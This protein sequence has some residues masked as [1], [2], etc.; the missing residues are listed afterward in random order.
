MSFNEFFKRFL[1]VLIILLLWAGLWA[2]RST[3]LM[4]VAS[5]FIAVALSIPARWLQNHGWRRPWALVATIV[6]VLLLA[7][8]L[9]LWLVPQLLEE[10][11]ALLNTIPDALR[12][13][14]EV[15]RN[16]RNSNPFLQA[17]LSE[18]PQLSGTEVDPAS[19]RALLSQFLN[20]GLA[21]A[22]SLLGGVSEVVTV[23]INLGFVIFIAVFFIVDPYSYVKAILYLTPQR[24]H[25]RVIDILNKLYFTVRTWVSTLFLSISITMTLV[26][27]ILGV[28]LDMPNALVV[29]V[30]AGVATFIPNIG[31]F[32]PIIP[33]AIFT[34][35]DDPSQLLIRIAA[36]LLIQLT[37]SNVLTPSLVKA[38]LDI[39][40]GGL[41]IF[42]LLMTFAFGA[43]GLLLA[44]PILSVLIVLVRE[45]F[46]YDLL[47]LRHLSVELDTDK[48]G[49]LE[50]HEH[51]VES[52]ETET[53]V[54]PEVVPMLP[55][56]EADVS[57]TPTFHR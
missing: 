21:I 20:A 44:V 2:A 52:Q 23:L 49:N 47:G 18:P 19:A 54:L 56:S 31:A 29:A 53:G 9:I 34:L 39:P 33:I 26:W 51:E 1:T 43:L 25:E 10:F 5:A 15:Y 27:L 22:P 11:G 8:V 4:G 35:D 40:A 24:Y 6:G 14:V 17:A 12:A 32:I 30:F 7:I 50:L 48:R 3:I 46:S 55:E 38:E 13:F 37:E 45:I 41:M 42:Q 28:L 57:G 36:Y 16:L